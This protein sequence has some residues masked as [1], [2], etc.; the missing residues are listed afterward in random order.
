METMIKFIIATALL[1]STNLYAAP[2]SITAQAWLVADENGKVLEGVNTGDVRSIASITKL[3]T[4]MTVLDGNQSLD[5]IISTKLYHKQ[6]S[7]R[8]LMEMAIV[9]S[10]NNAATILCEQYP[11]G[12]YECLHMMN[13]KV[14]ELEMFDTRLLDSTGLRS[15]NVSTP[16]DLLKLVQAASNYPFIVETSKLSDI[17]LQTKKNKWITLR[18]TNPLVGHGYDFIV[19]KTGFINKSGGCIVMKLKTLHGI[20]TVVL[21]GSKNTRTR[22]PEAALI[23][24]LY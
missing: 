24:K 20:R 14:Q 6:L 21:L 8:M 7:R 1:L 10:D 5:E 11:G 22:I 12:Y 4:V 18:N 17:K 3:I 19:S 15:E 2:T 16:T 9:K 23:S 13:R